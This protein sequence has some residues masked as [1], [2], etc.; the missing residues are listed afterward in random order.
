MGGVLCREITDREEFYERAAEWIR[1]YNAER[2][3][4]GIGGETPVER[5]EKIYGTNPS[6]LLSFNVIDIGAL[7]TELILWFSQE[8]GHNVPAQYSGCSTDIRLDVQPIHR[9]GSS[10]RPLNQKSID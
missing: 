7:S 9:M 6:K 5:F 10:Y 8:A 1:Y 2:P 3:H 4:L